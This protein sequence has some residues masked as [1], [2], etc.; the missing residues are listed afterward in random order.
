MSMAGLATVSKL[1][2]LNFRIQTHECL[3]DTNI[4]RSK[5]KSK[6]LN[7]IETAIHVEKN[8]P[9]VWLAHIYVLRFCSRVAGLLAS[10]PLYQQDISYYRPRPR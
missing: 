5:W 6:I 9:F 1:C 8:R 4:S 2:Q 10:N 7:S 3:G